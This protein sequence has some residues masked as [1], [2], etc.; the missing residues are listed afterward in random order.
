VFF[1]GVFDLRFF[2]DPY[3]RLVVEQTHYPQR[4]ACGG[5]H[6]VASL[7]PQALVTSPF[8]TPFIKAT[9]DWTV[10][11]NNGWTGTDDHGPTVPDPVPQT[12]HPF[13]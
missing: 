11:P 7:G 2:G 13:G 9:S 10:N 8:V 1:C 3:G 6:S 12:V 5:L 4:S